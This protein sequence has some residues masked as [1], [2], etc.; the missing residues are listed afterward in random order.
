MGNSCINL[1]ILKISLL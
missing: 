1:R